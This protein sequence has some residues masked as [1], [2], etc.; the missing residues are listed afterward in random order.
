MNSTN[1]PADHNDSKK[2]KAQKGEVD[3]EEKYLRALAELENYRKKVERDRSIL[4]KSANEQTLSAILPVLDNF[5]R[6]SEHLPEELKRHEWAKGVAA[7]EIQFEETLAELG[8]QKITAKPGDSVDVNK[9]AV[10]GTGEGERGKIIEIVEDG[11]ELNGKI[12]RAAKVR[13]GV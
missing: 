2:P 10:I 4:I 3:F 1:P 11:Y 5:K 13:V 6:A 8:L 7:I 9:H 12:L